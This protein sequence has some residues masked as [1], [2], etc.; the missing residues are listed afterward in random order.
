MRK[1]FFNNVCRVHYDKKQ[2][3]LSK[4]PM[5]RMGL[6]IQASVSTACKPS[7]RVLCHLSYAKRQQKRH[8]IGYS[9]AV[10]CFGQSPISDCADSQVLCEYV[11]YNNAGNKVSQTYMSTL[12]DKF[13]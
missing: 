9:G 1:L 12:H 6:P 3:K 11:V 4:R 10:A 8:I 13:T 2:P 7:S 5:A